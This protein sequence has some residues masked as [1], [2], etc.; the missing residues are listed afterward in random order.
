MLQHGE[1][2]GLHW[3][4]NK[5]GRGGPDQNGS[6]RHTFLCVFKCIYREEKLSVGGTIPQARTKYQ[7]LCVCIGGGG[8]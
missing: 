5:E 8:E 2:G 1:S 4:Q 7:R 6:L 3:V